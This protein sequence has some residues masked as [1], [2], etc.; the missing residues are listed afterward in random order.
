MDDTQRD[1][2]ALK[3]AIELAWKQLMQ[4][5]DNEMFEYVEPLAI[6]D[7]LELTVDEVD[8][9]VE[10]IQNIIINKQEK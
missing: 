10:Q 7:G 1:Y 5:G 2:I 6:R 9:L 8:S 4:I 3:Y